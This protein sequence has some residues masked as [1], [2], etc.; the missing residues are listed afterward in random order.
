MLCS[1]RV[2][3]TTLEQDKGMGCA[4]AKSR[5]GAPTAPGEGETKR[6]EKKGGKASSQGDSATLVAERNWGYR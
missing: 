5:C 6:E 3:D 1:G 2:R 4:A